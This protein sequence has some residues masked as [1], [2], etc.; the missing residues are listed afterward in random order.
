VDG[1]GHRKGK[2]KGGPVVSE[3]YF[4]SDPQSEHDLQQFEVVLR[5][6]KLLLYTDRGVFARQHVDFGTQLLI[7]H[8]ELPEDGSILDVGC[9]YGPIG[10]AVAKESPLRK[11]TMVDI[12]RRAVELAKK[13]AQVNHLPQVRILV[14]DLLQALKGETFDAIL[15]NPPI[16]AGKKVLYSLFEQ[17]FAAL[18][19]Q[20]ALWVVIQKK[21][22]APS[23]QKKLDALFGS[24]QTV[25][26]KK[27]YYVFQAKKQ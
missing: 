1:G 13:N 21:Q 22:G 3:H 11:V 10:L 17:S 5:G 27:G 2:F 6:Q 20:G 9:G 7:E 26:R 4:S 15:S 18:K 19:P 14:S 8:A 23:A 12:N 16:R 24:V 25:G